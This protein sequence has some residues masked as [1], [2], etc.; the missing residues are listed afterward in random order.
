MTRFCNDLSW[1]DPS[2][3]GDFDQVIQDVLSL[4]PLV[5]MEPG[6]I[7]RI[8]DSVHGRIETVSK[9]ALE[10][11]PVFP[12]MD[13]DEGFDE[14]LEVKRVESSACS[15]QRSPVTENTQER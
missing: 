6:R 15:D 7:D 3:L 4:N 8:V 11:N 5:G 1:F 12:G 2:P 14:L 13:L 9:R 10:F